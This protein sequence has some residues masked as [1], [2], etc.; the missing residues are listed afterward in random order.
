MARINE[1]AAEGEREQSTGTPW[2]DLEREF[3]IAREAYGLAE[4]RGCVSGAEVTDW[5]LAE[6]RYNARRPEY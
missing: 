6:Q 2:N 4:S 3:R 5:R 1:A